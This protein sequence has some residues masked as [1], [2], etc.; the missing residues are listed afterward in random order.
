MLR[1][2][3]AHNQAGSRSYAKGHK[4][5]SFRRLVL[6][7]LAGGLV[8]DACPPRARQ[9]LLLSLSRARAL[10]VVPYGTTACGPNACGRN[11]GEDDLFRARTAEEAA[12]ARCELLE[13]A[14]QRATTAHLALLAGSVVVN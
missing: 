1:A 13:D 10:A 4:G 8:G 2:A 14:L 12:R 5:H 6:E 9:D 11:S 3:A 7:C